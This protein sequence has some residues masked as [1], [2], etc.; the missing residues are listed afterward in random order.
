MSGNFTRPPPPAPVEYNI[1]RCLSCK[2]TIPPDKDYRQKFCDRS[3]SASYNN[4]R[5]TRRH[6]RTCADCG[7][8][9]PATKG[10]RCQPCNSE[11]KEAKAKARPI[12]EMFCNGKTG[13]KFNYIRSWAKRLMNRA[14]LDKK[15]DVCGFDV[16]VEVCHIVPISEFPGNTPMGT[17]NSLNNMVYL[18]PNHH[19]MFDRGLLTLL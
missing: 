7:R 17:V 13:Y 18:C 6:K 4:V 3:C 10:G 14:N 19:A 5:R 11:Y 12:S 16:V 15:C 1:M 8:H 9:T 2:K